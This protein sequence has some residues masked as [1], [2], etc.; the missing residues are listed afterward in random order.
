MFM[1][2]VLQSALAGAVV[3]GLLLLGPAQPH[4][5][6][7]GA[8]Q[9]I[10][11]T[12]NAPPEGNG[13]FSFFTDPILNNA[14]QIAF[15]SA[16]TGTTGGALDDFGI[17]RADGTTL[18]LIQREFAFLGSLSNLSFPARFNDAGQVLYT[19]TFTPLFST[20]IA[21]IRLGSDGGATTVIAAEDDA[22]PDGN[23]T[24]SSFDSG[25]ALNASGQVAFSALL[26]GTA[27]GTTDNAGIFLGSGT[28]VTQVARAGQAAPDGNGSF[29]GFNFAELNASG[30]VA[31]QGFFTGTT[32]G[33]T[34]NAGIFIGS[35]AAI[36]QIARAGQPAPDGNGSLSGLDNPVLNTSGQ[37]AFSALLT[38]TAGGTND[39][40]GIFLGSGGVVT[41]IAREGQAAP[42][43]NGLFSS[44]GQIPALNAA[45]QIAFTASLTATAGGTTD[46]QGLF[47]A[48]GFDTVQIARKGKAFAGST[49]SFLSIGDSTTSTARNGINDAGQVAY[50]TFLTDGSTIITLWTPPYAHWAA[51]SG[52]W[53]TTANWAQGITPKSLFDVFLDPASGA[54]I[55]DGFANEYV[56]SLTVGSTTGA[57]VTLNQ[58]TSDL[59]AVQGP[60]TINPA[61]KINLGNNRILNAPTL[62]NLGIITGDGQVNATLTNTTS[63]EIRV[64]AGENLRFTAA[65][66]TNAGR[67]EAIGGQVEFT[68][69]LTNAASTGLIFAR[70]AT[71]R[72]NGTL[73]NAGA[74]AFSFGTTDVF[75]DINNTG[76]I[77]VSGNTN[78]TFID[79]VTVAAMTNDIHVSVASTVVFFG[80]YNG[81]S[82]GT[83]NVFIEGDLRP[84]NSPGEVTYGGDLGL[85]AA[86]TLTI[87]LAGTTLGSEYDHLNITGSLAANGTLDVQLLNNFAPQLG[88]T[89]DLLDFASITGSFNAI[90]LPSLAGGLSFDTT[91]LLTTGS[92]SVVP[93]P[94][95][96]MLVTF[97]SLI[98][99]QRRPSKRA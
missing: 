26:T 83:G 87:E 41:Q 2:S 17:Y 43:G 77:T 69:D 81:G 33:I 53:N 56:K 7:Q 40:S 23:G 24:F 13:T 98:A 27:G 94:T 20:P 96:A 44:L 12:G 22:A 71:L 51:G 59:T 32:G 86:A 37:V 46:D 18:T 11:R 84:G 76:S 39:D 58:D 65:N 31:F 97:L 47:I 72:F 74:L 29:S 25:S 70:D 67:I 4:A 45:G 49:I 6:A 95:T 5:L 15:R 48:D 36:T 1:R 3:F 34:D 99:L 38:G 73:T 10:T 62:T 50:S 63:G 21:Q 14:G 57:Q 60:I 8:S 79:D 89:F 92:I 61:G 16:L 42:D 9:I 64:G 93:E 35:G 88:D 80:S 78:V 75:G 68:Q 91:S 54:T 19:A 66:N 28:A 52:S 30:Q 90:N 85:G 82:T 55:E